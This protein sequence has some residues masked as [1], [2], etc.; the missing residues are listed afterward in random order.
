M[1]GQIFDRVEYDESYK[2]FV[3]NHPSI[4]LLI[5]E[6]THDIVVA[7]KRASEFYGYSQDEL[8]NMN[9]AD[10][11]T[12]SED[13]IY[14][15]MR[16]SRAEGRRY[17]KFVH[18]NKK[19]MKFEVEVKAYPIECLGIS[20]IFCVIEPLIGDSVKNL[21]DMNY[22][23]D[24][25]SEPVCLIEG[26]RVSDSSVLYFNEAF[27]ELTERTKAELKGCLTK[28]IFALRN[29]D[30]LMDDGQNFYLKLKVKDSKRVI[31]RVRSVL[32]RSVS[33]TYR[34]LN[35]TKEHIC[36]IARLNPSENFIDSVKK[37]YKLDLGHLCYIQWVTKRK[38]KLSERDKD[39]EQKLFVEK[40]N[41]FDIVGIKEWQDGGCIIYSTNLLCELLVFLKS[42]I[43]TDREK[44][45]FDYRIAIS[46]GGLFSDYMIDVTKKTLEDFG[47]DDYHSIHVAQWKDDH[48]RIL[49]IKKDLNKA[50]EN[51]EFKLYF[52]SI[53][54]IIS[55]KVE[56]IEVLVRW[57]HPKYGI[58]LPTE[59]IYYAEVTGFIKWLDLYVI[60]NTFEA[61]IEQNDSFK[62]LKTHVNLSVLTLKSKDFHELIEAYSEQIDYSAFVFELTEQAEEIVE[63]FMLAELEKYELN[64]AIDDFGTG[65]SNLDRFRKDYI[66]C[67]KFDRSF[68]YNLVENTNDVIIFQN[69][70]SMCKK[71]DKE[72][73]VEGVETIEQLRFL[74]NRGAQFIQ[75]YIFSYPQRLNRIKEELAKTKMNLSNYVNGKAC[76]MNRQEK[77]IKNN[78]V[79]IQEISEEGLLIR[80]NISLLEKLGH[81]DIDGLLLKDLI[82]Y[83]YIKYFENCIAKVKR[84][85]NLATVTCRLKGAHG[86]RHRAICALQ[87]GEGCYRMHV[88]LSEK[89]SENQHT[90]MGLSHNY[91][92]MFEESPSGIIVIDEDFQVE[93]WNNSSLLIFGYTAAEAKNNSIMK[94]TTD[95]AQE[96]ALNRLINDAIS[97][98]RVESMIENTTKSGEKIYCRWHIKTIY[99]EFKEKYIYICMINDVT[100]ELIQDRERIRVNKAL[101]QSESIIIMT[102]RDGCIEYI[103]KKFM[104]I[105]GYSKSEIIGK[106]TA[107]LSSKKYSKSYFEKLLSTIH[108]GQIWSG[109]IENTKK[110]GEHYWCKVKIYPI[111]E[112]NKITGFVS[113]QWDITE[114][115]KLEKKNESLRNKL[116]EQDKIASLGL[117]TSGI[118][119]EINNPLGYIQ[120]NVKY[121]VEI[122]DDV[123]INDS[124]LKSDIKETLD[125]IDTG[126]NQVRK[127]AESFK[128]YL[129]KGQEEERSEVDIIELIEE[130]LLLSKNEYKYHAV[131]N[132]IYD[133]NQEYIYPAFGSKLKQVVMNLIINA[134]HAIERKESSELGEI[135]I[136]VSKSNEGLEIKIDDDGCGM[137]SGVRN[138][139]FEPFFTTKKEGRGTGLGLS[140]SKK[141]IE[142]DHGG[143]LLCESTEGVGTTFYI[144]I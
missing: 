30:K 100:E 97:Y 74:E 96:K 95:E 89:V 105:T 120:S 2:T 5:D 85:Q 127:I 43:N 87:K 18:K 130:V 64:W 66:K 116:F 67:V 4:I 125:D 126:V 35:I 109:E 6:K 136:E 102:D 49:D 78:D 143:K 39:F 139:I 63:D 53:V 50:V 72:V 41:D 33:R 65:Y 133:K 110:N 40:M 128:R 16:L 48:I 94:L 47:P 80:P 51:N 83:R 24:A 118:L 122:L 92:Q 124:D 9:I 46:N 121:L 55:K 73:I 36:D 34:L 138:K 38:D 93:Q 70:L 1:K 84:G 8:A 42:F 114:S 58:V 132:L 11:N 98:E 142:E 68:I 23:F 77:C 54:N 21:F 137:S 117:L 79:Y 111:K 28:N 113:V 7:N 91:I 99:D 69:L 123:E 44:E 26:D 75:G 103:N 25:S 119:H 131:C 20:Y 56:G 10:I 17:F 107:V 76:F 104:E 144:R 31:V 19:G 81:F 135:K 86:E 101:D 29:Q 3:W 112:K 82:E 12:Y 52:Q 59:F 129:F 14:R 32:F 140:V 15:E 27:E 141:I 71:L 45:N 134:A 61:W 62:Y 108:D 57:E 88:E 60:K 22:F 13:E 37:Y 115:K 106:K 90:L